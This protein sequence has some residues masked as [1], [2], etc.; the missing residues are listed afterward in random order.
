MEFPELRIL[1]VEDSLP[2]Q[3]TLATLFEAQG[4]KVDF[5]AT[6]RQ[7]LEFALHDPPDVLVLDLGLPDL[8]GLAVCTQL[9]Q[10][11]DRHVPVLML[12]A[13][14]ALGD[15]LEGF[16]AG[17][18]DY[19]A[20]PFSGEELLARCIVLSRRHRL[21]ESH[22]LRVGELTIDRRTG[23]RA[24]SL[25]Q[26]ANRILRALAESH[27]RPLTRTELVRQLWG[28]EPPPSDPLR[29]HLYTLRRE[30]DPP[31]VRPML[32]SIHGVGYRLD[33]GE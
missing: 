20:K 7:G 5:A 15:K 31:G 13:R 2:L 32:V 24:L 26:T 16:K 8:D 14:D 23:A 9:R 17:A 12:T 29:T 25:N 28:D 3:K 22:E 10:R 6:G 1:I 11:A 27:P 4:C 19:L 18:D 30:L 21:G 33:P